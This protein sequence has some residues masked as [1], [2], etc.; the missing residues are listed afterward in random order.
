MYKDAKKS[1]APGNIKKKK[2]PEEAKE[3]P[4]DDPEWENLDNV[5]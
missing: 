1:E 3:T 5:K 4:F 2:N